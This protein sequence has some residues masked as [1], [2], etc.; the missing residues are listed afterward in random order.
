MDHSGTEC[1]FTLQ[2]LLDPTQPASSS[3]PSRPGGFG[4]QCSIVTLGLQ[5]VRLVRVLPSPSATLALVSVLA[6]FE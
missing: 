3:R 6:L 1:L 2:L 5:A 4:I